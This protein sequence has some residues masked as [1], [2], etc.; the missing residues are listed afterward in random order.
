MDEDES[1]ALIRLI[2]AEFTSIGRADLADEA[3]YLMRDSE[4]GEARLPDR[5]YQVADMLKA[6]ERLMAIQD[7]A[8]YE[9]AFKIMRRAVSPKNAPQG[10]VVVPTPGSEMISPFNLAEAPDLSDLRE[11]VRRL[12]SR[13]IDPGTPL[14][15]DL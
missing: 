13:I 11:R 1:A 15:G 3:N 10:A 12:A 4:T 14:K 9:D 7:R 8:T 5:G 6:F 2:G